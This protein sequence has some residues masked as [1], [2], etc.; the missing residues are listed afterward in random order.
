[1]RKWLKRLTILIAIVLFAIIVFGTVIFT[2]YK[3]TPEWYDATTPPE[4][5]ARFAQQAESKITE[6]Q[7]WATLLHGDAIRSQR[8]AQSNIAPPTTRVTD[9]HE[10]RFTQDELNALFDKWSALHGWAANY[11]EYLD[12]PRII[13]QKDRLVL[14]AKV[15][16]LGAITSFH[17]AP[18]LDENKQ[19]RLDLVKVMGG[20]LPLPEPLWKSQKNRIMDG[21]RW[22]VPTWQPT[23]RIDEQGAANQAAMSVTLARLV[24]RA[25]N[26]QPGE[27]ILFL[28]LTEASRSVPV[29]VTELS[30]AAGSITLRVQK[31]TPAERATL[32]QKIRAADSPP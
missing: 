31:L 6:T 12:D 19:L 2:L 32:I 20:R 3:G 8:A 24:M 30:V 25:A 22:R 18:R 13:L 17:F 9:S 7:N 27:P 15:K 14:A 4:H 11:S 1:M 23:A 10:I 21:L 16:E 29:K 5:R 26:N 28:P